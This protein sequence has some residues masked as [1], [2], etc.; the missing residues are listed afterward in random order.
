MPLQGLTITRY[1]VDPWRQ[2]WDPELLFGVTSPHTSNVWH[3]A[4]QHWASPTCRLLYLTS[5][6]GPVH[7]LRLESSPT[8]LSC[9]VGLFPGLMTMSKLS[10]FFTSSRRLRTRSTTACDNS[11]GSLRASPIALDSKT[12]LQGKRTCLQHAGHSAQLLSHT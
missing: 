11:A 12:V 3:D 7:A 5:Q 9:F 4:A 8:L 2:S 1:S 6:G 10:T